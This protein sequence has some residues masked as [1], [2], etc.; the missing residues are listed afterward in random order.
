MR[1]IPPL[2]QSSSGVGVGDG[3]GLDH[4]QLQTKAAAEN[5]PVA[6]KLLPRSVRE[7]LLAT[8]GFARL[9]DDIGD[10]SP[11]DRLARL[12]WAE[13]ELDRALLGKAS[14]P[15]F[16]ALGESARKLG[17]DKTP[18]LD[19][20]DANRMDQR[21]SRYERLADLETYC[22]LSANPVGRI[23]LAIF[24]CE[25]ARALELSDAICTGLQLV[26]HWQDVGEDFASG[27]VYIPTEDLER[28]AVPEGDL[29]L[30][31]SSTRLRRL[32]AFE[33]SRAAALIESG[34][35]L[36]A[37]LPF[38]GRLAVAG[39]V[40]GGLAQVKAFERAG[41][42]V[43]AR[44]VKAANSSVLRASAGVLARSGWSHR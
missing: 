16:V 20:I 37:L 30:P 35:P 26:E 12:D 28:F 14:H 11:G 25:D 27:R 17:T 3:P 31:A 15:V 9:V 36:L 13:A 21:V 23:V 6:S 8:Y 33:V 10:L 32:M 38:L 19:L 41:Y 5:F 34:K 7:H 24:G 42:D 2:E 18:Y 39:F 22:A 43:L 4:E 29:A 40:G 1:L 44:P